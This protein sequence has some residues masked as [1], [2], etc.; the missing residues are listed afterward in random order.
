MNGFWDWFAVFIFASSISMFVVLLI[1][2]RDDKP[3]WW[4]P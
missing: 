1:N 3:D 2:A 4:K